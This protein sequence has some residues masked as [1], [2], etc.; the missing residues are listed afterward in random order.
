MVG[1]CYSTQTRK[2]EVIFNSIT[3]SCA[4]LV[5]IVHVCDTRFTSSDIYVS[6]VSFAHNVASKGNYIAMVSTKVETANPEE[7]LRPGLQLLGP[8]E[9]K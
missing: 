9:E 5:A 8:V 4:I 2:L 7:E 6:C 3:L 1:S